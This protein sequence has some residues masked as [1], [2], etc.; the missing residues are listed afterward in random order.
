MRAKERREMM[1]LKKATATHMFRRVLG[2]TPEKKNQNSSQPKKELRIPIRKENSPTA[3]IR[4]K[5]THRVFVP[6]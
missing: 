1:G 3:F 2:K 5:K 4:R 6:R